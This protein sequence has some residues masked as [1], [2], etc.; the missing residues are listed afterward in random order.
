MFV[1]RYGF[2]LRNEFVANLHVRSDDRDV[3][4]CSLIRDLNTGSFCPNWTTVNDSKSLTMTS[5]V[6]GYGTTSFGGLWRCDLRRGT[7]V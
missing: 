1:S 3:R 5:G 2:V 4:R 7:G 6:F